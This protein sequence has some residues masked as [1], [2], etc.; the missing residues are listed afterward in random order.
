MIAIGFTEKF[1]DMTAILTII[2]LLVMFAGCAA[3]ITFVFSTIAYIIDKITNQEDNQDL[4]HRD[5]D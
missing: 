2:F 4:T 5:Y 3:T 1:K